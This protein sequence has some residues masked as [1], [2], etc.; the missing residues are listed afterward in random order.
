MDAIF[1]STYAFK[2]PVSILEAKLEMTSDLFAFKSSA[3]CVRVEIGFDKSE[4]LLT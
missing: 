3:S 1:E 2:L 4:V